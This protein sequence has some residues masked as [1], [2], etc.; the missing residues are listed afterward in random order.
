MIANLLPQDSNHTV[1]GTVEVNGVFSNDKDIVWSKVVSYVDQIDRLHGY[2]TVKETLSFAFDCCF[3]GTH[4]GPFVQDP[5]DPDIQKIVKEL[6]DD[7]WL[8]DV[9]MRGV[10]LKR[11]SRELPLLFL[12]SL[13]C[14]RTYT[15]LSSHIVGWPNLLK[16]SL[17]RSLHARTQ[18]PGAM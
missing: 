1:D 13:C 18:L 15:H 17:G 8:V 6:D 2:L 5:N 10:G 14:T 16:H 11:V 7:G 12:C 9:I 4:I 3:G